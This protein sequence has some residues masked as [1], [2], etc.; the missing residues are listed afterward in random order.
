MKMIDRILGE[1]Q[2]LDT[3]GDC[4]VGSISVE[5]RK[6]TYAPWPAWLDHRVREAFERA[7]IAQP[8]AHQT[9]AAHA[10]Y[11]QRD[12]VIAT[13]TGSGKSLAAWLPFFQ[14]TIDYKPVS[15]KISQ[16][17][18]TPTALYIAPTKALARSQALEVTKWSTIAQLDVCVGFADGDASTQAKDWARANA[19][20]VVTNPDYL[21]F[22]MLPAAERWRQFI[23]NLSLIIIDELH[24]YR[25][26]FGSH[27]ALT[28]RRLLR[29]ARRYGANP[30]FCFLSATTANPSQAASWMSGQPEEDIVV[31]DNETSQRGEQTIVLWQPR[32]LV[33]D[34]DW[35]NLVCDPTIGNDSDA[36]MVG[37]AIPAD[38]ADEEDNDV[39]VMRRNTL[40]ETAEIVAH[41]V[42]QGARVLAF[43]NSRYGAEVV[44]DAAIDYSMLRWPEQ[45]NK[46]ASYRGGYLPE[47][48]R[49]LEKRLRTGELMALA[50]T[51]ALEL[52][53]DIAGLD[54]TVS[55][56]WPGTRARFRQQAGRAARAGR[57]GVSV[58]IAGNNPLDTYMLHH[59]EE[60]F[61]GVETTVFHPGNPRV[62]EPHML[63]AAAETPIQEHELHLFGEH[64]ATIL[65]DLVQ[66]G[67]LRQRSG[68]YYCAPTLTDPWHEVALRETT[69]QVSVVELSSGSVIGSVDN[70]R[71]D[72]TVFPGAIYVHQGK[73][74]H[75]VDRDDTSAFVEPGDPSFRTKARSEKTI[76]IVSTDRC[77]AAG[78]A[79]TWC[80]GTIEVSSHV[81]S[82][83]LYR[84]P[85]MEN[86]GEFPLDNPVRTLYTQAVWITISPNLMK[87]H[88]INPVEYAG[89]LHGSE[90][91]L[92][93]MLPAITTCDRWDIGGLSIEQHPETELPTIFIYDGYEGGAG[94]ANNGYENRG[95]W[96]QATESIVTQCRCESGCPRC[97]Q[98]PKCGNNN[99]ILSKAGAQRLLSVLQKVTT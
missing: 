23:S 30:R 73:V 52:G 46:I 40:V 82:Y 34:D 81:G 65:G 6:A 70:A 77:C 95:S 94:F 80:C 93:G 33:T 15:G 98:S 27:I 21:H 29:V 10:L 68:G 44:R 13:G 54:A 14:N 7:G 31:V 17:H 55:A 83:G 8:Y 51:S 79:L 99:E 85:R 16:I 26:V 62:V 49:E 69:W 28:I 11:Q 47:E 41:M 61:E 84:L 39:P 35:Q 75:V 89:A 22:A 19:D 5:P 88:G 48:R 42:A 63:C 96:L 97:I 32:Q 74:F 2:M 56:G 72:A 92:I 60:I 59:R 38:D 12:V 76:R 67:L 78:S 18:S 24:Y 71:A 36:V 1:L 53:I 91:A 58:L 3:N 20:I 9:Q 87:E 50:S 4:L 43:V 45:M 66:R 64:A 90:H 25:G 86:M 37:T 57:G